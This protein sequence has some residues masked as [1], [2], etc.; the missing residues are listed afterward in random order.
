MI[1]KVR[2][3]YILNARA[4]LSTFIFQTNFINMR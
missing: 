2:Y 3:R 4:P 1:I